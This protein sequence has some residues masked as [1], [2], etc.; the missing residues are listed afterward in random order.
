MFNNCLW[1]GKVTEKESRQTRRAFLISE[2]VLWVAKVLSKMF[3]EVL[4]VAKF[5]IEQLSVLCACVT[6]HEALNACSNSSN[7][8]TTP[9]IKFYAYSR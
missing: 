7:C 1:K 9:N 4:S 8:T 5:N 3:V 2:D 6:K